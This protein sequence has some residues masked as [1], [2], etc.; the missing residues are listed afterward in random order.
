MCDL[1]KD[2]EF[3][4]VEKPKE[5]VSSPS[6]WLK[7]LVEKN[8]E[9]VDFIAMAHQTMTLLDQ[10]PSVELTS[11]LTSL[12]EEN[13]NLKKKFYETFM[14]VSVPKDV[15]IEEEEEVTT[16]TMDDILSSIK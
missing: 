2:K 8:Q 1:E 7:S 13:K 11:K 15:V 6:E 16:P 4:D 10:D 14:G 9:D 12:E 5:T 3:K